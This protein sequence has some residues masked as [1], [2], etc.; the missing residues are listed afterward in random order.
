MYLH[1]TLDPAPACPPLCPQNCL[2]PLSTIYHGVMCY[3][4]LVGT[5]IK[6]RVKDGLVAFAETGHVVLQGLALLESSQ[7][8]Y[9]AAR[10]VF[11]QGADNCPPHAPLFNA[12]AAVEVLFLTICQP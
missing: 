6:T 2:P 1:V 3:W 10:Q 12:W 7:G 8:N 5:I 4:S 9:A 11:Q